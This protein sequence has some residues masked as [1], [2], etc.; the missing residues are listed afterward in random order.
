MSALYIETEAQLRVVTEAFNGARV[1]FF[2]TEFESRRSGTELC[3]IQVTDGQATF[4][5]DSLSISDLSSLGPVLGS[6]GMTWVVHAGRQDMALL[7]QAFDLEVRPDVYD[8]QVAWSLVSAEYQVSLAYLDA[9]LLDVRKSKGRQTSNWKRRPLTE[10]QLEYAIGDVENLPRI[11]DVI[12]ERLERLGRM[13]AVIPA[14]DESFEKRS[15]ARDKLTLSSYRN[16]W[17]LDAGQQAALKIL[18]NWYNE[19]GSGGGSPHYKTLFSVASRMP[20]NERELVEIKGINRAWTRT[21]GSQLLPVMA[22]AAENANSGAKMS[23]APPTPYS[24]FDH[25]FREAW[26]HAARA[27]VS[28]M[29]CIAPELAFPAWLMKRFRVLVPDVADFGSLA[30]EF[31]GWRECLAEPW[32]QFCDETQG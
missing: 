19:F 14:S 1:L 5:I 4:L 3:L 6:A 10:A 17:Q 31:E 27:H 2:D 11:Y 24:S 13:N 21:T 30:Q 9:V 32:R 20:A 16:L 12:N 22:E 28:A 23:N 18:I 7:M 25:H 8:T 29:A 15:N 26:L